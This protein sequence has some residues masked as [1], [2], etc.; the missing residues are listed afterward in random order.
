MEY[1]KVFGEFETIAAVRKGRSLSRLG[2]GEFGIAFGSGYCREPKNSRLTEEVRST[3][4]SPNKDCLVGIPTM[5]P[6]GAR[7]WNWSRH[8]VRYAGLLEGRRGKLY[9]AFIGRPEC[10]QWIDNKGYVQAVADL[11]NDKHVAVV[12]EAEGSIL[13]A[14]AFGAR[15]IDHIECLFREAYSQIDEY[16]KAVVALKPDIAIL[17]AG[18]TATCLA[19]RLQARGIQAVDLGSAGKFL[20]RWLSS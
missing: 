18:P 1:P 19:N 8:E 10:A 13:K 7:Y 9:S 2:D 4:L 17:C 3:L 6:A 20:T 15:K 5:D 11:W 12:C 16:E 14:L